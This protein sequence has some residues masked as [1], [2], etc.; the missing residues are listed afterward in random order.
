MT[1]K[2]SRIAIPVMAVFGV[3][4]LV[5]GVAVLRRRRV[6]A[7]QNHVTAVYRRPRA[8]LPEVN[9]I[10]ETPS[11][12]TQPTPV[13]HDSLSESPYM[14]TVAMPQSTTAE[15]PLYDTATPSD[16]DIS[17]GANPET[18]YDLGTMQTEGD[19]KKQDGYMHVE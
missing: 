12:C 3:I 5:V 19:D 6:T 16:A 7:S 11:F 10:Y 18:L 1:D 14:T 9:G 17:D 2:Y 8:N 15:V 4:L 13:F